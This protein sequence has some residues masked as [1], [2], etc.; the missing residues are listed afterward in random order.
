MEVIRDSVQTYKK[1][2]ILIGTDSVLYC[3]CLL[4]CAE[5]IVLLT[6]EAG[7]DIIKIVPATLFGLK[8]LITSNAFIACGGANI[9]NITEWL[10]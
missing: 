6:L 8:M 9:D 10:R 3:I 7:A 4:S 5:S 2:K 1:N